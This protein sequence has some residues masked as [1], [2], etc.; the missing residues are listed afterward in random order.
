[1]QQLG[2]TLESTK[3]VYVSDAV[4]TN[5]SL[6]AE[7]NCNVVRNIPHACSLEHLFWSVP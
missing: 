3:S 5:L 6:T 4:L 7:H 2:D 1:M